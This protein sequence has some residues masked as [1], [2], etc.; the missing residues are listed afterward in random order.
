[1]I[2][3]YE[4]WLKNRIVNKPQTYEVIRPRAYI[5]LAY[6]ENPTRAI[7]KAKE[8]ARI[9]KDNNWTPF[10]PQLYYHQ[11]CN[12][13]EERKLIMRM[14][15]EEMETSSAIFVFGFEVHDSDGMKQEIAHAQRCGIPVYR[16]VDYV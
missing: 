16:F 12:D 4:S 13:I 11:F 14:C 7:R 5:C 2:Q 3:N 9:A 8:Y 10:A 6:T 1:M 15:L